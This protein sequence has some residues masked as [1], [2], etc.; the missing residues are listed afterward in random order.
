MQGGAMGGLHARLDPRLL[1]LEPLSE[2]TGAGLTPSSLCSALG[3][4]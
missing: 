4:S 1:P 2:A 3:S